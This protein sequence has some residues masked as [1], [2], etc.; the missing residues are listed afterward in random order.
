MPDPLSWLSSRP[1]TGHHGSKRSASPQRAAASQQANTGRKAAMH[2]T[3]PQAQP[4]SPRIRAASSQGPPAGM[5]LPGGA[6]SVPPAAAARPQVARAPREKQM[7][8]QQMGLS[9]RAR[10]R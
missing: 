8:D 10:R 3:L 1:S 2:V 7:G 6:G 9:P 4:G 5:Q